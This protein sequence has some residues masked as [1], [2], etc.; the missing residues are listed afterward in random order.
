MR[1]KSKK[2]FKYKSLIILGLIAVAIAAVLFFVNKTPQ[3]IE[4]TVLKPACDECFDISVLQG[5]LEKQF[6]VS[7]MLNVLT[8]DQAMRLAEK[9]HIQKLPAAFLSGNIEGLKLPKFVKV[10]DVLVFSEPL[11]PYYD[12]VSKTVKGRVKAVQLQDKTC[13]DCFDISMIV[14]QVKSVGVYFEDVKVVDISSDEGKEL[15]SKYNI[16]KLPT[17]IFNKEILEYPIV[18]SVWKNVGTVEKDGALVLR[19]LNPPYLNLETGE[20]EGKVEMT[21]LVDSSCKD[22]YNYSLHKIILQRAIGLDP[23]SEKVVDISS[24]EGKKLVKKYNIELVPTI[25]LSKEAKVY[26]EFTAMWKK[27]GSEEPDGVFVF[28]KVDKIGPIVFMNLTSGK[29]VD[30]R[31]NK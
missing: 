8:G 22:C 27:V 9:Y 31:A 21:Y 14:D 28:R 5:A 3:G 13:T 23:Y 24:E 17:L 30:L 4:L 20:V 1:K 29:E 7:A 6:N 10:D 16:T 11:P 25:L 19:F 26:P 15:A 18:S 12:L 2:K